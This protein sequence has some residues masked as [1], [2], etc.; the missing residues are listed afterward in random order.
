M[1][2]LDGRTGDTPPLVAAGDVGEDPPTP[3]IAAGGTTGAPPP[4]LVAADTVAATAPPPDVVP[5]EDGAT[6]C[7]PLAVAP[8]GAGPG[9]TGGAT[10]VGFPADGAAGPAGE[11]V[12]L[13]AVAKDEA[14]GVPAGVVGDG[15]NGADRGEPPPA[16][17]AAPP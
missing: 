2:S 3:L 15:G 14:A 6:P 9:V 5:A 13:W 16:G 4:L 1:P 17:W 7:P 11:D 10:P 8:P 12:G